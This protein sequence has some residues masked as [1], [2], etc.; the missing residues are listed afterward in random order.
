MSRRT[1]GGFPAVVELAATLA[2]DRL[3]GA[4]CVGLAQM[5]D[6]RAQGEADD[7]YAYR[8]AAA[9]KVCNRCPVR[10]A[11]DVVAG[12]LAG[13]AIGVWAGQVRGAHK[14]RGRPRKTDAA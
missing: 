5:F 3:I 4:N 12:E 6:P 9:E 13:A 8:L 2:D 10:S 11:C 14:P 7:D 1:T